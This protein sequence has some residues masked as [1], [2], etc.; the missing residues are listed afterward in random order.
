MTRWL[1]AVVEL[2]DVKAQVTVLMSDGEHA[3]TAVKDHDTMYQVIAQMGAEGWELAL[4]EQS[5]DTKLLTEKT[6]TVV[7][8]LWL[9]KPLQG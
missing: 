6:R 7:R 1:Y 4:T 5:T 3:V 2:F 8:R 9:K